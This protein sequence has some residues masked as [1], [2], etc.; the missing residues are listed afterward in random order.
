VHEVSALGLVYEDENVKVEA[1]NHTH[2]TWVQNFDYRFTTQ[3]RVVVWSGD[4]HVS[5]SFLEAARD[6]DVVCSEVYM[7][8]NLDN[9]PWGGASVDE[10]GKTIWAYHKKPQQLAELA[11]EAN[12]KMLVLHHEGNCSIPYDPEA[13]LQEIKRFYEGE[14]VSARDI[15]VF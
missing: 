15:D 5:N 1:F 3:D 4:G 13:Q 11:T 2:G 10:K 7:A 9:V 6:A 14:V 12:V 8:A